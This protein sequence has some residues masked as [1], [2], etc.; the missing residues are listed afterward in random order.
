KVVSFDPN[1]GVVLEKN[2]AYAWGGDAKPASNI[3]H[4]L[5]RTIPDMGTQTAELLAGN[6]D[7]I[8]NVPYQQGKAIADADPR[9]AMTIASSS[10]YYYISLDALGRSGVKALTDERVRR[11]I[12]MAIDR[13]AL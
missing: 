2:E 11:A 4:L 7:L 6:I 5:V 9:F 8:R 12:M 3:G 13:E 1:Q 10:G